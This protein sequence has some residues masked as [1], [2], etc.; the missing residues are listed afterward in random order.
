MWP[1][2]VRRGKMKDFDF[3]SDIVHLDNTYTQDFRDSPAASKKWLKL[4][5]CALTQKKTKVVAIGK[6]KSGQNLQA[7]GQ[8]IDKV[9][10]ICYLD[11]VI[12][13]DSSCDNDIKIRS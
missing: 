6:M 5:V 2:V 10:N 4:S 9:E 11:S 7:G 13:Q 1:K 12:S 3:A 8:V